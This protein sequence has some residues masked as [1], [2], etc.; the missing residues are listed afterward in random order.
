Y[1]AKSKGRNTICS[2]DS[3][4]ESTAASSTEQS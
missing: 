4:D 1:L 2:M 3:I